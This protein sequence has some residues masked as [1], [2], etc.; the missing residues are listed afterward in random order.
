MSDDGEFGIVIIGFIG[1]VFSPYYAFAR[2]AGMA[3]PANHCAMN[4]ALYGPRHSRWAMTERGENQL[5]R[6]STSLTIGPSQMR[7]EGDTLIVDINE[8]AVPLPRKIRGTIRLRPNA[9]TPSAYLLD[10]GGDHGWW[11]IAPSSRVEV[12]LEHPSLKWSGHG[13]FDTNA[14]RVPLEASF[15]RWDWS[16][17]DLPDGESAILYDTEQRAG[18]PR[19]LA[20]RFDQQGNISEFEP[21]ES[22][23]LPSTLWRVARQTRAD[24]GHQVTV[25]SSLEDAPFYSRSVLSTHLL[26]APATAVHES[27]SLDR[28]SRPIVQAMLPFRMPRRS[29]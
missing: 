17:A 22:T 12:D 14:G 21:P 29:G 7:W 5:S 4:V 15:R 23:P 19:G 16:R 20:L 13:Y 2:R 1:S 25:K 18:A 27:L 6:D 8:M 10:D 3:N 26:G 28:F 11:P 9:I 24:P